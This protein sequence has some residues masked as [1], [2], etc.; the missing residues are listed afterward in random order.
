[1]AEHPAHRPDHGRWSDGDPA[2]KAVAHAGEWDEVGT[3]LRCYDHPE[4]ADILAVTSETRKRREVAMATSDGEA[5]ISGRPQADFAR[6]PSNKAI[7][8]IRACRSASSVETP[9]KLRR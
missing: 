6:N 5:R 2:P 3:L 8:A 7:P 4:D 1:M 9:R